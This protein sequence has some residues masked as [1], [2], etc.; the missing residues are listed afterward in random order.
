MISRVYGIDFS[1][2][3]TPR[4]PI[5][6]A[7]GELAGTEYQLQQV[8]EVGDWSQFDGFLN[9]PGPWLA[10]FDLPFSLPRALIEH[11][12]WP[13]QWPV[14][15]RW[16]GQ[17]PRAELRLAFKMF[18]DARPV[19]NKFVYR[20][21]DRPA[22]SSPAMRWTNPP[23]AWMLHAGAPRILH[24]GLHLPGLMEGIDA[25]AQRRIALEAY[26][27]Y[28]AR[29]ITRHSYKS[30]D[31]GKHTQERRDARRAIVNGLL[32]TG[33]S[34]GLNVGLGVSRA[35]KQKLIDDPKG[36]LLDAVIC[37][38]QAAHASLEKNFGFPV[39]IDPLEG[40][41][42]SVPPP[43]QDYDARQDLDA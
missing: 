9:H 42:A 35:W 34:S 43:A 36:D 12:R 30:D 15:I 8:V 13:T 23:V 40:W 6:I 10:G 24:A 22:G 16:Y 3:P 37:G 39:D 2:A 28:T 41:I 29:K 32:E 4:K 31:P 38:L 27:G 18:C 1:S 17:Q 26:P 25:P 14:F 33:L 20:K 21:T 19:G 11:Y 7:I 5:T